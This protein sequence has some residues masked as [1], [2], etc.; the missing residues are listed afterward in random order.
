MKETE[1][2]LPPTPHPRNFNIQK[3]EAEQLWLVWA[4]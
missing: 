3:T 4:T 1:A 2:L